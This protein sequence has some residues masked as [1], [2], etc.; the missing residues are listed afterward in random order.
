MPGVWNA[1]C[2]LESKGSLFPGSGTKHLWR[3]PV[4]ATRL[5]DTSQV[6][7]RTLQQSMVSVR[8]LFDAVTCQSILFFSIQACLDFS[9]ESFSSFSLAYYPCREGVSSSL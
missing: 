5:R 9:I 7:T 3:I 6:F 8:S 4:A 2:P 1:T